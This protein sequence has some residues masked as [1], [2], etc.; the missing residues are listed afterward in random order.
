MIFMENVLS[1]TPT[2]KI[3]SIRKWFEPRSNA[4]WLKKIILV[5][6]ALRRTVVS[7][8]R[9]DKKILKMAS[10]QAV[11]TS[12]TNNSPSQDPN[13]THHLFQSR[14]DNVSN[15]WN[16]HLP[17]FSDLVKYHND[18]VSCYLSFKVSSWAMTS[19]PGT[20]KLINYVHWDD[21]GKVLENNTA[22]RFPK[23]SIRNK[24]ITAWSDGEIIQI[25]QCLCLTRG[26]E[27]VRNKINI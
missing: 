25:K 19:A 16:G 27:R 8:W 7:D 4:P 11:E 6:R 22:Q 18:R 13:H 20:R 10:A 3:M 1:L 5:T 21:E 12:V 9:F 17:V 26:W 15:I 14:K 23:K 2:T 24:Y